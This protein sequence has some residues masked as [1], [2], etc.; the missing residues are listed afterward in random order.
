M[1][2]SHYFYEFNFKYISEPNIDNSHSITGYKHCTK[3]TQQ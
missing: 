2:G 1:C 3:Y